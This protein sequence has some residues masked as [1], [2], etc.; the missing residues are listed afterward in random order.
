MRL[1]FVFPHLILLSII[2]VTATQFFSCTKIHLSPDAVAPVVVPTPPNLAGKPNIILILADDV[3]YEVPAFNGG[4]SYNTPNLNRMAAA[5]VRFTNCF[6]APLSSPSRFMLTTGKYN[7]RNYTKWGS[8]NASEVTVANLLRN[9]GYATCVAGKWQFDGG[10]AAI[11]AFGY[12]AYCVWDAFQNGDEEEADMGSSYKDPLVYQNGAYLPADQTTGKYGV[13]IFNQ[14]VLNFI[15]S[16]RSHPFFIYY[17]IPIAHAPFSPTPDDEKYAA[18][19]GS[20]SDTSYYRSMVQYIDKMIDSVVE[21]IQAAGIEKNTI[22]LFASDNGTPAGIVSMANN[23]KVTGDMGSTT[24]YG[25]HVPMLAYCPGSVTPGVCTSFIEFPDFLPT[26]TELTNTTLPA[27]FVTDGMS[28]RNQLFN[29][30][31]AGRSFFYNYYF[32]HP[33][34]PSTLQRQYVQNLTYKYYDAGYGLF[35]IVTDPYEQNKITSATITKE[36]ERIGL[37]FRKIIDSIHP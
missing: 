19:K 16:N 7:F 27:G 14:Y 31:Y 34:Y 26:I 9:N 4:Q 37:G 25:T 8:M 18:W 32:P 23:A 13:D 21:K 24:T 15:D 11:K 3:G 22:I 20:R 6:A 30:A 12:D 1:K 10:D 35:N 29:P 17:P 28:F 5:G 33:E 2:I 36:E